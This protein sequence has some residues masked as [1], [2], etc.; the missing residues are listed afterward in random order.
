[1]RRLES[2]RPGAARIKP[3][4]RWPPT[5]RDV[6][7]AAITWRN[8]AAPQTSALGVTRYGTAQ[9]RDGR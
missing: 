7:S 6:P 5:V 8:A 2:N 4:R 1:M 3:A 9:L